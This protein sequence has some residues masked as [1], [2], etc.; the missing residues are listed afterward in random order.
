MARVTR[1]KAGRHRMRGTVDVLLSGALRVRVYAGK[2]PV[3]GR[4]RDLVEI[5]PAGPKAA[6]QAEAVRTR[7]LNQVDE[8]RHP[9]T[10]ATVDQLLDRHFEMATLAPTT[11]ATYV[12]YATKHVR[13]LIGQLQGRS[14]GRGLVRFLLRRAAPVPRPLRPAPPAGPPDH[15]RA[16]VRRALP[17]APLHAAERVGYPADPLHPQRRLEARCALAVDRDQPHPPSRT[18]GRAEAGSTA[19]DGR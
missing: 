1:A 11:L 7:L 9:R 18:A 17:A 4:R 14:A 12:G 15:R 8:R 6:A 5:V 19:A 10:S 13:P 16:R 3:S 2:D